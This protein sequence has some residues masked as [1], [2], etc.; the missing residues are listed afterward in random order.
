MSRVEKFREIIDTE[1]LDGFLVNSNTDIRYLVGFTGSA[2]MLWVDMERVIF[3]TD[4]R[5]ETQAKKQIGDLAEIHITSS[6]KSYFDIMDE[7]EL[8]KGKKVAGFDGNVLHYSLYRR[9]IARFLNVNWI[10]IT[11]PLAKLR[12]IKDS[13]EINKLQQAVDM[14][15]EALVE[16][17][18]ILR[19]GITER[20]FSAELEYRL[21]RKGSEKSPFDIIVASGWRASLPHGVASEKTIQS[22][23][24]VTVDFGATYDGYTS[25]LTRTFFIGSPDEKFEKIYNIVLQAQQKAIDNMKAGMTGKEIDEIARKYIQKEGYGE[26]FGHGL[27]HGIGLQVHDTPGV[28]SRNEEP[29]PKNSVVTVEPGIYIPDWGGVRIEDDVVV[30]ESGVRIMS[31]E[32]PKKLTDM[33]IPIG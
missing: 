27:G 23:E 5:Y 9:L 30:E 21:N 31:A 8:L 32:L 15:I 4:F 19:P 3:M 16:T 7:L 13:N 2:G 17:L 10:S 24:M 28:N 1:R 6:E 12:S 33:I 22:G 11:N 18:P 25:D 20:E 29:L 14:A 26:Y